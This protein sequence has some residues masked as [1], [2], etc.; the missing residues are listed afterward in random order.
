MNSEESSLLQHQTEHQEET[1]HIISESHSCLE[2]GNN[3]EPPVRV[4][5]EMEIATDGDHHLEAERKKHECSFCSKRFRTRQQLLRHISVHTGEKPYSCTVCQKA[6]A[7]KVTL[8]RHKRTHTGAKPYSCSVCEKIRQTY[9]D[10][11]TLETLFNQ[12]NLSP[13]SSSRFTACNTH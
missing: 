8:H 6:F 7:R 1:Q 13:K 2:T 10:K 12:Q 9:E 11:E 5:S 4:S 3:L